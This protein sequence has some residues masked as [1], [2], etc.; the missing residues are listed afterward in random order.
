METLPSSP[1]PRLFCK[2]FELANTVYGTA[3]RFK[4]KYY[5]QYF[6]IPLDNNRDTADLGGNATLSRG[7]ILSSWG[8]YASFNLQSRSPVTKFD[9]CL[10]GPSLC[11]P[12]CS[13]KILFAAASRPTSSLEACSRLPM[14]MKIK[15]GFNGGLLTPLQDKSLHCHVGADHYF[16]GRYYASGIT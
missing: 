4:N 15:I 7:K 1:E 11:T 8:S 13:L 3:I 10:R 5:L 12:S 6:A 16:R 9:F 2:G 14:S